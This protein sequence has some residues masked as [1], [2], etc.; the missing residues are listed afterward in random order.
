MKNIIEN[1]SAKQMYAQVGIRIRVD[2]VTGNH[3]RPLHYLG[4]FTVIPPPRF[5]PGTSR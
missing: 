3:D 5:E 4:I 2:C 1:T